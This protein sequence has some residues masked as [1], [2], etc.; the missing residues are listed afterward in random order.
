M[1][2]EHKG[3]DADT[4][5]DPDNFLVNQPYPQVAGGSRQKE[6]SSDDQRG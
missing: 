4:S 1:A 5:W 2:S 6:S 3:G